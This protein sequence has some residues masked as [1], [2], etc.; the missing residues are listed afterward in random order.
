MGAGRA[1]L[2]LRKKPQANKLLLR[3]ERAC[4]S[5]LLPQ[6][7]SGAV[8]MGAGGRMRGGPDLGPRVPRSLA[9]G[10]LLFYLWAQL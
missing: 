4:P 8:L 3:A 5:S 6:A 7:G 10:A 9:K 1:W 2:S